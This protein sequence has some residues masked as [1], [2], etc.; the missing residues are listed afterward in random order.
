MSRTLKIWRK[1]VKK[2]KFIILGKLWWVYHCSWPFHRHPYQL[3]L[4][5]RQPLLPRASRLSLSLH[6]E[7]QLMISI[8]RCSC[9]KL[10]WRKIKIF[11]N[12]KN[13]MRKNKNWIKIILN[14]K[15]PLRFQY[16]KNISLKSKLS[17]LLHEHLLILH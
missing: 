15:N 11:S 3:P 10:C 17:K 14:F 5:Y 16:L 8:H 13:F 1:K 2:V 6:D 7:A 9:Q 12:F 4:S